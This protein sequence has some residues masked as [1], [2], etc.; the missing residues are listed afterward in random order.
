MSGQLVIVSHKYTILL[1]VSDANCQ[2]EKV[3][4][5]G[6]VLFSVVTFMG[7]LFIIAF[8]SFKHNIFIFVETNQ[9]QLKIDSK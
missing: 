9:T 2:C 5:N 7:L 6:I 4:Y 3:V 8:F 1:I